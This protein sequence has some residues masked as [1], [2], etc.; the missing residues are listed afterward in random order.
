MIRF[1]ALDCYFLV[2]VKILFSSDECGDV[3]WCYN[4]K[5]MICYKISHHHMYWQD[6]QFYCQSE[7]GNL[8]SLHS[9]YEMDYIVNMSGMRPSI[10][11]GEVWVGLN[12]LNAA[13]EYS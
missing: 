11:S 9:P 6:A 3:S 5:N 2:E 4:E 13:Q 7:Q 8:V 12:R 1:C 10:R